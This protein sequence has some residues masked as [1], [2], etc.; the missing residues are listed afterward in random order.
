M[1]MVLRESGMSNGNWLLKAFKTIGL[2]LILG[3]SLTACVAGSEKWKEEVQLSDGKII[4]IERE[5]VLESGGAEWA[6]NRKG[7][8]P[9]ENRLY[10]SN[11]NGSGNVIE[12]RSVKKSPQTWPE[13]PLILDVESGRLV[14][15]SSVF[16]AGGCNVYS[17]YLYQNGAWVEEKLPVAF[18][19][20]ATNLFIFRSSDKQNFINLEAKRKNISNVKSQNMARVGPT[21]PDCSHV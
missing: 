9:K 20:R 1:N 21:N 17:K 19:Q 5:L 10:F 3:P 7:V 4:V 12:W 18:E 15:F 13:V 14:I 16:K 11:P 6:S 8:K 2:A